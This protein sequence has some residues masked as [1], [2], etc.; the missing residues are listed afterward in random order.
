MPLAGGPR[1]GGAALLVERA[2]AVT[3][4]NWPGVDSISQLHSAAGRDSDI[5]KQLLKDV[6][7]L[8][9]LVNL[10]LLDFALQIQQPLGDRKI[11]GLWKAAI[12]A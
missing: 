1:E 7:Y 12:G 10:E 11:F 6:S 9:L 5:L 4:V 2:L 3:E 8:P